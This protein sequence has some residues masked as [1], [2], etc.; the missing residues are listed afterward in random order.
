MDLEMT[1]KPGESKPSDLEEPAYLKGINAKWA[2]RL[3]LRPITFPPGS[4]KYTGP[5]SMPIE[6][7]ART[8][9]CGEA[10]LQ[11]ENLTEQHSGP[12]ASRELGSINSR[13][14]QTIKIASQGGT[15]DPDASGAAKTEQNDYYGSLPPTKR[16]CYESN[17]A[18]DPE[19]TKRCGA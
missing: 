17:L 6:D 8:E 19:D 5:N 1:P 4:P 2:A 14:N 12:T 13:R 15:V 11:R 3:R 16:V 10:K 9:S 7:R 18:E